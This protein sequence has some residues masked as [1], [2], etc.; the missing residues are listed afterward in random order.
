MQ[1][2]FLSGALTDIKDSVIAEL[3]SRNIPS[4]LLDLS[5]TQSSS[6]LC[7]NELSVCRNSALYVEMCLGGIVP[8]IWVLY[9]IV[10]HNGIYCGTLL[11]GSR[12]KA[13]S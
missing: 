4:E 8:C 7:E 12:N 3:I 11:Q 1:I 9:I 10:N 13:F 6:S 5:G 2:G